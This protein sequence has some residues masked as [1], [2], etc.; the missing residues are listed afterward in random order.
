MIITLSYSQYVYL[1]KSKFS[2]YLLT[3]TYKYLLQTLF[4]SQCKTSLR[5]F[6]TKSQDLKTPRKAAYKNI[7]GKGENAGNQYFLLCQQFFIF[8]KPIFS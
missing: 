8:T 5:L 3:V 1:Y 7:V 6:T 2:S 4:I